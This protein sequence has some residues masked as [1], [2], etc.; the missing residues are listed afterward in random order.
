MKKALMIHNLNDSLFNLPLEKYLL[1]F[2][3][4][5]E[6]HYSY[7]K[8]ITSI[9]TEKIYFIVADFINKPGY[10]SLPQLQTIMEDGIEIG[11]HSYYHKDLRELNLKDKVEHIK[12][13]TELMFSWFDKELGFRP[14]S[15]CFPY[16]YD[17]YNI[18][19][20]IVKKYNIINFYGSERIS[21]ETLLHNQNPH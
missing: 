16:N 10:L 19:K 6:D 13:D 20:S 3:D 1:T 2:D 14:K 17:P 21:I 4:G 15:F 12:K 5:T 11:G 7:L 8:Q 9:P 18:Y